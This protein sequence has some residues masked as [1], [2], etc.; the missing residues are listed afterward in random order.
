MIFFQLVQLLNIY[1][2]GHAGDTNLLAG[3][4]LGNMLLNVCCFAVAQGLNG[5]IETFVSQSFGAG[6][7]RMCGVYLN[8]ARVIVSLVLLPVCVMFFYTDRILIAIHQDETIST[9]ARNYCVWCLPGVFALVQFDSTKRYLQSMLKSQISTYTQITT[10]IIHI[11]WCQLYIKHLNLEVL[12]A[13]LALNT[14]YILNFLIQEFYIRVIKRADFE[15]VRA[16]FF[17]KT[18]FEGWWNFLK[19]GIPSTAMMCFEWWAFEFLAIFAGYLGVSEL[20]A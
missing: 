18:T 13:A 6:D 1:Y 10:T 19:L 17:T 4:G 20:S 9:M 11:G 16:P 5:A 7:Y 8:R 3:V 14:T 2:V 15:K 12:G